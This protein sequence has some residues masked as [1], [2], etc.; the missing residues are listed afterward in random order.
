MMA[1]HIAKLTSGR[2]AEAPA[3]AHIS[4][5][6]LAVRVLLGVAICLIVGMFI[7][8]GGLVHWNF[9]MAGTA[10]SAGLIVAAVA[11]LVLAWKIAK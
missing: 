1:E 3:Q 10:S 5:L 11:C 4:A 6:W 8:N 2:K 9:I 7:S